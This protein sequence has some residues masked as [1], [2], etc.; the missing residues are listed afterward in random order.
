MRIT[1]VPHGGLCNRLNAIASALAYKESHPEVDIMIYWHKWY[2]CNCRYRDLFR[3]LPSQYPPVEELGFSIKNVPGHKL[4]LGLP[5]RL[6]GLWYDCAIPPGF[7]A[8]LFEDAVKGKERIYVN[9]ENRFCREC[10][11]SSLAEI[12]VPNDELNDRIHSIVDKWHSRVIGLHIRRTD[13][14]LSISQ[15]PIQHFYKVIDAELSADQDVCFYV[16]TDD[17]DVKEDLTARY[18][19]HIISIPLNLS[20]NSVR[21][22]KDAV[23]DLYCLGSTEKIYGSA[24]S[25]YSMFA[26]GLYNKE[27]II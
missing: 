14:A 5:R 1:L 20:R 15:S 4:N 3:Q 18:G 10:K 16:A 2:L 6:R 22:M 26:A 13:N 8:N 27:L 11:E 12:F 19:D 9:K 7:N 24:A 21:G 17:N 25:T 23:V